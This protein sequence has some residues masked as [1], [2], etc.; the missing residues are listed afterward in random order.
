MCAAIDFLSLP[1]LI[2]SASF[3]LDLLYCKIGESISV[4]Q[5]CCSESQ[6]S[7][8]IEMT[9]FINSS[10]TLL[11]V[12]FPNTRRQIISIL[13]LLLLF[14]FK[15]ISPL[16]FI[17]LI[18]DKLLEISRRLL[19][20]SS[21]LHLGS[22]AWVRRGLVF[23]LASPSWYGSCAWAALL[24]REGLPMTPTIILLPPISTNQSRAETLSL[25]VWVS[26]LEIVLRKFC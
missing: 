16:H 7:R 5:E 8:N 10:I 20:I 15:V 12:L 6:K 22:D 25:D 9:E 3:Y 1:I 17:C 26:S 2:L 21:S 19:T 23:L 4:W 13:C 14:L 11:D 18:P 24:H